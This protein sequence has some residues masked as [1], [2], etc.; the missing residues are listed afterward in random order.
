MVRGGSPRRVDKK[1]EDHN[2][3]YDCK[4]NWHTS[5]IGI[6]QVFGDGTTD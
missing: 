4:D 1:V 6:P 2:E 3:G 5:G